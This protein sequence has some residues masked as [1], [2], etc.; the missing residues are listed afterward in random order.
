M[1]AETQ[2]RTTSTSGGKH[3]TGNT[4]G[5]NTLL[6]TGTSIGG[7][8]AK[9]ETNRAPP[10][11]CKFYDVTRDFGFHDAASDVTEDKRIEYASISAS[12]LL[13]SIAS[14]TDHVTEQYPPAM[15]DTLS[16]VRDVPMQMRIAP[17]PGPIMTVSMVDG[18]LEVHWTSG[19]KVCES[20]PLSDAPWTNP[21]HVL[22]LRSFANSVIAGVQLEVTHVYNDNGMLLEDTDDISR[23]TRLTVGTTKMKFSERQP[24]LSI[25]FAAQNSLNMPSPS[26]H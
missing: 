11:R 21:L 5:G 24:S 7:E 17:Q 12:S 1:S 26:R 14:L 19:K 23:L 20:M 3:P 25:A 15:K 10:C 18:T 8:A 4:S 13:E 9:C 6:V 22:Q 16:M 2:S